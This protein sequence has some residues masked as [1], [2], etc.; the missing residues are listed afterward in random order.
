MRVQPPKEARRGH[1]VCERWGRWLPE[2]GA[3][4]ILW[5]LRKGS[6]PLAAEPSLMSFL[7]RTAFTGLEPIIIHMEPQWIASA[8][9]PLPNRSPSKVQ[10]QHELGGQQ[11]LTSGF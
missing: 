2:V 11:C 7:P 3:R 5:V 8:R 9:A 10:D 6:K 4:K 1:P